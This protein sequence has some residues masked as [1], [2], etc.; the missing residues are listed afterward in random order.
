MYEAAKN[1]G[2]CADSCVVTNESCDPSL[3]FYNHAIKNLATIIRLNILAYYRVMTYR[4][5]IIDR[6]PL[7]ESRSVAYH[8]MRT[9]CYAFP[10]ISATTY[11]P[12]LFGGIFRID[13]KRTSAL[14]TADY[15]KMSDICRQGNNTSS[16][17]N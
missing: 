3:F 16:V 17:N 2:A 7:F 9:N 1:N 10:Y 6:S 4:H 12:V 8:N 14:R 5:T 15:R 11:K 13:S